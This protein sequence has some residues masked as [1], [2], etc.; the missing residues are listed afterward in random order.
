[1]LSLACHTCCEDNTCDTGHQNYL[2]LVSMVVVSLTNL[3]HHV[4]C[5][6]ILPSAGEVVSGICAKTNKNQNCICGS[7]FY[8]FNMG[9]SSPIPWRKGAFGKLRVNVLFTHKCRC[10]IRFFC[11]FV[12]SLTFLSLILMR[13]LSRDRLEL[14]DWW[15]DVDGFNQTYCKDKNYVSNQNTACCYC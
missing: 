3:L 12:P 10:V 9:S 4:R 14:C 11:L 8:A 7:L 6:N 15:L 5:Y 13:Y 2:R 1:M